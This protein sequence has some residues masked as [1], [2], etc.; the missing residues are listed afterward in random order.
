MEKKSHMESMEMTNFKQIYK[1]KTI[2]ITGNTGFMGTWLTLWLSSLEANVIG[3]S[4]KIFPKNFVSDYLVNEGKIKQEIQDINDLEVLKKCVS[5]NKPEFIFHLAAQ[6]L[7]HTSYQNPVLTFQTNVMGTINVLEAVRNC[8]SVKS[9]IIVTSDKCYDNKEINYAYKETDPLGGHDPYSAS[10]G[11]AEIVTASYKNSFF[12]EDGE[13]TKISTVRAG[14]I[15]GGGDWAENR[16]VPDC[17]NSIIQKKPIEVRSPKSIRPWQY[18]LEP[19]SGM[20]LLAHKMIENKELTNSWNFGPKSSSEDI[21]V[22]KLVELIIKKWGKGRWNDI[23]AESKKI[24]HEAK[25]LML[26][27]NK[28]MSK[29]KW[30][31]TYTLE[32]AIGETVNWYKHNSENPSKMYEFSLKQIEN[33]ILRAK[34][35]NMSWAIDV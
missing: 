30:S 24:P 25:H 18:A 33:Y 23:S 7:V 16:I 27:S 31:P 8:S 13:K 3:F 19:I 10:K 2:F 5:E 29:L 1:D 6:P 12:N 26:D 21:T 9:C 20:L 34:K 14:N 17:I 22:K 28:A 15:I 4:N 35:M 11:A 32:E